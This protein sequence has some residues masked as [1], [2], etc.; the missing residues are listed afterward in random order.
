MPVTEL[1]REPAERENE[2]AANAQ[3]DP[4]VVNEDRVKPTDFGGLAAEVPGAAV[5]L[6]NYG[7]RP[8]LPVMAAGLLVVAWALDFIPTVRNSFVDPK[9]WEITT[10]FFFVAVLGGVVALALRQWENGRAA[11]R[12]R[13]D[14]ERER[15]A[16]RRLAL[17]EFFRSAV[18]LQHEYKKIRRTL[19]AA[20]FVDLD[21]NRRIERRVFERLMDELEDCQLKAES[22]HKQ[23]SAQ[24]ELFGLKPKLGRGKARKTGGSEPKIAASAI[25]GSEN[26]PAIADDTSAQTPCADKKNNPGQGGG[27]NPGK[28]IRD[29]LK[30]IEEYL[31]GLLSQY[32]REFS[33]R[34]EIDVKALMTIGKTLRDFVE[35][36]GDDTNSS[37]SKKLLTPAEDVRRNILRLIS[38]ATPAESSE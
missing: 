32:E 2:G 22:L 31:R 3:P 37:I 9:A 17:V 10:Q 38:D 18:S 13:E 11:D 23:V 30:G 35:S 29:G 4:P 21:G 14:S 36:N 27:D 15:R 6:Q 25:G 12:Q 1:D 5:A 16:V 34:R 26:S 8:D 19:R 7:F 33:A 24:S 20:S 28:I